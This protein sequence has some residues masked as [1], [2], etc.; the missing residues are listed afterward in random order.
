[1]RIVKV[2]NGKLNRHVPDNYKPTCQGFK[3]EALWVEKYAVNAHGRNTQGVCARC[4]RTPDQG[5]NLNCT[6]CCF[7]RRHDCLGYDQLV[8][9][10]VDR[11]TERGARVKVR[12]R[13]LAHREKTYLNIRADGTH[14]TY[15]TLVMPL[16]HKDFPDAYMTSGGF[17]PEPWA[18]DPHMNITVAL[19]K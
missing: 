10:T 1:L 15:L 18:S 19:E 4:E 11:L 2:T 12:R 17:T 14:D 16:I 7:E 5:V 8:Q 3:T 13:K 9:A 6:Q